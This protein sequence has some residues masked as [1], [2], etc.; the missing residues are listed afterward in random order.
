[1]RVGRWGFLFA[2]AVSIAACKGGGGAAD[3]GT[4]RA[5]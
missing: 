4:P 2:V 5:L 1:M 3:A